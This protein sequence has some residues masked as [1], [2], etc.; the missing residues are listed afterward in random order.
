MKTTKTLIADIYKVLSDG[1][2][3]TD[4]QADTFGNMMA[5]MIQSRLKEREPRSELSMSMLG[6]SCNRKLWYQVNQ[7]EK[8]EPLPPNV[9]MKFLYGDMVELL[10]LFLAEVA[11]HKVEARG[12]EVELNGVKGHFDVVLDGS[13][14]DVKSASGYGFK[15]FSEHRIETDDPFGYLTQV[16]SYLEASKDDP[17]VLIKGEAGFLAIDKEQGHL[18]L[19]SYR[20][21]QDKNKYYELIEEKKKVVAGEM[22]KRAFQ[23]KETGASGNRKLGVEC[24][25]CAFKKD[26]WPGLKEYKYANGSTYL[27]VVMK[28]PNV[29]GKF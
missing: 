20:F 16:G 17:Q 10:A 14:L 29:P 2:D 22:P 11:G 8:A 1:V 27:T 9:R 15:K 26:C 21:K 24:S 19:D 3:I 5:D 7:P 25:Y 23:D 18:V 28:E 6:T 13:L 12:Q 4:E